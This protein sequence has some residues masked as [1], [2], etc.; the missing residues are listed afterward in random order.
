MIVPVGLWAL[1]RACE[2]LLEWQ[3][4]GSTISCVAVN[5]SV[6][7]LAR[8]NFCEDALAVIAA[9]GIEPRRITIE[10]TES[11]LMD[12]PSAHRAAA[13][14]APGRPAHRDR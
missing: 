8:S 1:R 9:T 6:V 5:A 4:A 2:Q 11:V 13:A 14:P 7:Q 10:V 12:N 3:A